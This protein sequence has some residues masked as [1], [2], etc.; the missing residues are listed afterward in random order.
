MIG[1]ARDQGIGIPEDLAAMPRFSYWRWETSEA[2]RLTK[3][4]YATDGYRVGPTDE[5]R[6]TTLA[7]LVRA[8]PDCLSKVPR[9]GFRRVVDGVNF[10]CGLGVVGVDLD[11]VRS[12]ETGVIAPWASGVVEEL[13][14]TAMITPSGRGIRVFYVGEKPPGRNVF[15]FADGSAFEIYDEAH[16]LSVTG[17]REGGLPFALRA[18]PADVVEGVYSDMLDRLPGRKQMERA[19]S[20]RGRGNSEPLADAEV[21]RRC[22]AGGNGKAI[23]KLYHGDLTGFPASHSEADLRVVGALLAWAKG[24]AAQ[25]ER[26]FRASALMRPKWD[27]K[28]GRL[29]YGERTIAVALEGCSR[30]QSRGR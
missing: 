2:G 18:V 14:S 8:Q 23:A 7:A 3:A 27:E 5:R 11:R 13:N 20:F 12:P 22:F 21:L 30:S 6:L 15:K 1:M 19:S 17:H 10:A 9:E 28:H 4:P 29:T 25:A 26:L 24:D 16:F